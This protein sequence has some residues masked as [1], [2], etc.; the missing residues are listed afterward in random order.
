VYDPGLR[1]V[2][3]PPALP[4]HLSEPAYLCYVLHDRNVVT[5]GQPYPNLNPNPHTNPD[6]DAIFKD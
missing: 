1:L 4:H 2:M 6:F 5:H 3:M